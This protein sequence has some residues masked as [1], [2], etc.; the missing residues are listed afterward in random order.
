MAE[1][2]RTAEALAIALQ[3]SGF[4]VV[5]PIRFDRFGGGALRSLTAKEEAEQSGKAAAYT[6][7]EA[8]CLKVGLVSPVPD[9]RA[10]YVLACMGALGM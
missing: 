10:S 9:M 1:T 3:R 2:Q 7:A 5:V 8:T 4:A 6:R